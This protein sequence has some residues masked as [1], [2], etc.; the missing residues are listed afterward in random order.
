[1]TAAQAVEEATGER[2]AQHEALVV[3]ATA[4]PA[5]AVAA[6]P[7]VPTAVVDRL[8]LG[9]VGALEEAGVGG[10]RRRSGTVPRVMAAAAAMLRMVVFIFSTPSFGFA[11]GGLIAPGQDGRVLAKRA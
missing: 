11:T 7:T 2:V 6:V 4:E 1:M 10:G 3:E 5:V 9:G 8:G